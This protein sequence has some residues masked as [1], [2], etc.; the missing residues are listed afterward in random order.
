MHLLEL[1]TPD[2]AVLDINLGT[3]TTWLVGARLRKLGVRH[4]F[5]TGYGD[6]IEHPLEHRST[7]AITKPYTSD[8][9]ARAFGETAKALL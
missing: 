3:E 9:L 5:A 2:F 8:S 7:P 4:V 1:E 6:S